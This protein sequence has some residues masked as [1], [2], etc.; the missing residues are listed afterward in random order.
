MK[1]LEHSDILQ[2]GERKRALHLLC[3]I[4]K[5]AQV[6]PKSIELTG[7]ECNLNQSVNGGGFGEIDKGKFQGETVCVKAVR[8]YQVS[9]KKLALRVRPYLRSRAI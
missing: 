5:S 3:K 8:M 6:F 1:V 9:A 7:V 2:P 4:A